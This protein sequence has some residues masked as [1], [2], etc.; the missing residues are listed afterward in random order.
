MS[1]S[2]VFNKVVHK[3]ATNRIY[4][5]GVGIGTTVISEK[6][7]VVG[8]ILASGDIVAFSDNR[9]KSNISLIDNALARVRPEREML[10]KIQ[11]RT[12]WRTYG[13][14]IPCSRSELHA[15]GDPPDII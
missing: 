5:E 7:H 4:N 14:R 10:P 2:L 8:N 6:L 11:S 12:N 9:L 3:D 1:N 13:S 15:R